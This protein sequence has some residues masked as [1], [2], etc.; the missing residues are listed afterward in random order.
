MNRASNMT[1]QDLLAVTEVA[2]NKIIER[3]VTK[4]DVQAAA[5]NAKDQILSAI[6]AMHMDNQSLI[7]QANAG[8]DQTWR[9][10]NELQAQINAIENEIR[11]LNHQLGKLT[12]RDQEISQV[13]GF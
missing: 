13:Q 1:R 6:Q 3:L 10:I 11:S 2:K 8:H 5:D 4:L 12:G 7:R 9:K